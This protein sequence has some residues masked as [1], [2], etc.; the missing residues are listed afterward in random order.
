M[1]SANPAPLIATAL[2]P[3]RAPYKG[4]K[5]AVTS[6]QQV[7]L[8]FL[9]QPAAATY[10]TGEAADAG[11]GLLLSPHLVLLPRGLEGGGNR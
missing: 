2:T 9:T 10:F 1:A 6:G 8:P 5:G 4:P 3:A 7:L 11:S